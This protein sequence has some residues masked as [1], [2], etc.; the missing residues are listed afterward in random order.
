MNSAD[1]KQTNIYLNYVTSNLRK[2]KDV[3]R[4]GQILMDPAPY[5]NDFKHITDLH[6][7]INVDLSLCN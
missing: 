5:Q 7:V 2:C 6:R 4:F 3:K 1:N